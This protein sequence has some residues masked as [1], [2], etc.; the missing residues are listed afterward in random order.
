MLS[1]D[2]EMTAL[3]GALSAAEAGMGASLLLEGGIGAGKSH[4][5][6]AALR[7]ARSKGFGTVSAR[8]RP[9]ERDRAHG[10]LHQIRDQLTGLPGAAG[11]P[12]G[13]RA[14]DG[15]DGAEEAAA[16]HRMI[17]AATTGAPL[18]VAIDD[19]QWTDAPS[20]HWLGYLTARLE[21]LPIVLLATLGTDR[22]DLTGE[23]AGRQGS[24]TAAG[25]ASFFHRRVV[26][27]GLNADSVGYLLTSFL[28]EPADDAL[29]RACRTATG[30]NPL[31]LQALLRELRRTGLAPGDLSADGV[32]RLAPVEVAETLLTRLGGC[33]PEVG[34]VLDAVSIVAP[35]ASAPLVSRLVGI[36][37]G[38]AADALYRL[39]RRGI[40]TEGHD[41]IGF[42]QPVVMASFRARMPPSE[43]ARL[44]AEAAKALYAGSAPRERI[45]AHLLPGAPVGERWA[46][47]LLVDAADA[48]LAGGA[49]AEAR[50]CLERGLAECGPEEE[51]GLL[52]RLGHIELA[53]G[54][55]P[56]VARLRRTVDLIRGDTGHRAMALLDLAQAAALTGDV[57]EALRIVEQEAAELDRAGAPK[58]LRAGFRA[59]RGLLELLEG[60]GMHQA[61]PST[62]SPAQLSE[63]ARSP[64]VRRAE[65]AL[66]AVSAQWSGT[67]RAEALQQARLA[68][69]EPAATVNDHAL[70]R[71][72]LVLVLA[73]SGAEEEALENCTALLSAATAE[74]SRT[75]AALARAVLAEC[76]YRAGRLTECLDAAHEVLERGPEPAEHE[77]LGS[78]MARG[79]LGSALYESG[80][81]DQAQRVLL[82]PGLEGTVPAVTLPGL[83]FHRGRLQ[84]ALGRV[85]PGL[86]D[87]EECGRL[88]LHRGWTGPALWPWR[89]EAA[90]AHARLGNEE[91]ARQLA[92]EE[93]ALARAF[94]APHAVGVALRAAGLLAPGEER[95][96][97]LTESVQQ[98]R[99]AG[100]ALDEARA[101]RDLGRELMRTR[102]ARQAREHLRAAAALA[103]KCAANVLVQELRQDMVEA[104]AR[105]RRDTEI[106]PASLTPAERR[107]A[108]LAAEGLTNKEI[109]GRLYVTRRTVEMHLSRV[110]RKLSISDRRALRL[111]TG[112]QRP[113]SPSGPHPQHEAAE[114][115]A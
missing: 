2:S 25:V 29:A 61:P 64:W 74:G 14:A 9:G 93:L 66:A 43:R 44:H 22:P 102:K 30:G 26:L 24:E 91:A 38:E 51:P 70:M 39:V 95:A 17:T 53:D 6:R 7:T 60:R 82:E 59:V 101:L 18:L 98:L 86:A 31:L 89:S 40:L 36:G 112:D 111:V 55:E 71:L 100:A 99:E 72:G 80:D 73:R 19:L 49:L 3:D 85:G 78:A 81:L 63:V 107:T 65:A 68:L 23:G 52:R 108:L 21:G 41:G 83:L 10:V 67:Q 16:V 110:Y 57:P 109:A 27:Q 15:A 4:L 76:T 88:L 87:L 42:A 69:S 28:G 106:G 34:A 46:L 62:S 96:A 33:S 1:R 48:A 94:G 90:L 113:P 75:V 12:G 35:G 115:C 105:P 77:W 13:P 50:V 79:W 104:G 114:S 84:V 54:P 32:A 37:A 92:G 8:A 97:L 103:E 20:L 5:V 11:E 45:T 58:E 47:R 56:A